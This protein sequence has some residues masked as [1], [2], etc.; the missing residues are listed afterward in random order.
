M[1]YEG[2]LACSHCGAMAIGKTPHDEGEE[3]P[4]QAKKVAAEI[5]LL[6]SQAAC[7]RGLRAP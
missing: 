4:L 7:N 2:A 3:C 6:E 5:E 1:E